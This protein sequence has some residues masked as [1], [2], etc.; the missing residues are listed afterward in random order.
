MA[1][2]PSDAEVSFPPP[3]WQQPGACPLLLPGS[4]SAVSLESSSAVALQPANVG[5]TW[6]PRWRRGG[7]GGGGRELPEL[8]R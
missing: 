7:G 5:Y 2:L 8:I 6:D 4:S 3:W 1:A